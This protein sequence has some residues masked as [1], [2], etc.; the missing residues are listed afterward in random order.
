[1]QDFVVGIVF[2]DPVA[3]D[4]VSQIHHKAM[5]HIAM[6]QKKC[7]SKMGNLQ[8][9]WWRFGH[10][11]RN[12]VHRQLLELVSVNYLGLIFSWSLSALSV[13]PKT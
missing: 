8:P 13:S 11:P 3:G 7:V 9:I 5:M 10:A 4:V 2:T 1:L 6:G 12:H